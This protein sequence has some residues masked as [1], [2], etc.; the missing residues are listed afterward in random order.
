MS[1]SWVKVTYELRHSF[2]DGLSG[3]VDSY[4]TKKAAIKRAKVLSKD[5][6][7]Y[8]VKKITQQVVFCTD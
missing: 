5:G 4:K 1:D 6:S 2:G 3:K 8:Y 7:R